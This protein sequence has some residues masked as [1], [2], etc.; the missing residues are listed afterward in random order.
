[1]PSTV[2]KAAVRSWQDIPAN[3]CNVLA[4]LGGGAHSCR[5]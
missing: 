5:R 1:M 4:G 3:V 2:H